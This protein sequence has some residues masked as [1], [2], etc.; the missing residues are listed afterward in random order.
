MFVLNLVQA[1]I[2]CPRLFINLQHQEVVSA[3]SAMPRVTTHL[4]VSK[5]II[6]INT[7]ALRVPWSVIHFFTSVSS[8]VNL[9]L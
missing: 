7:Q 6:F 5:N 2:L 3:K 9:L 8:Q 4:L 1:G